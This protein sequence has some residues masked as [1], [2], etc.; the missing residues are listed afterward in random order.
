[1]HRHCYDGK[2][3]L[4]LRDGLL[5]RCSPP[6]KHRLTV[7][8][9]ALSEGEF[10]TLSRNLGV[11]HHNARRHHWALQPRVCGEWAGAQRDGPGRGVSV[12]GSH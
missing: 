11:I 6:R 3:G 5:W 9:S 8:P 2:S 10:M 4:W 7:K 1:M 12:Q